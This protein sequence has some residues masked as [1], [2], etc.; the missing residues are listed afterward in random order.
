M[1]S[2]PHIEQ[3]HDDL[4]Q[5]AQYIAALVRHLGAR[6]DRKSVGELDRIAFLVASVK[7]TLPPTQLKL[8]F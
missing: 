4:D 7:Q 2:Q 1:V 3:M 5:A 6:D 8:P